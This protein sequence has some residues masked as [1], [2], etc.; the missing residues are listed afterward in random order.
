MV[1][2]DIKEFEFKEFYEKYYLSVYYYVLKKINNSYD[3]EDITCNV[4]TYCYIHFSDYDDSRASIG[5]W[6]YVIVNSRIKNYYRDKKIFLELNQAENDLIN[7]KSL[8]DSVILLEEQ[9]KMLVQA[10]KTLSERQQKI[11]VL[12]Y[13]C[14]KSLSEIA[15]SLEISYGNCRVLLSR[16][17]DKLQKYCQEYMEEGEQ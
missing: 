6:L 15:E 1:S 13:F 5:T 3:A 8:F 4:F 11:V 17:L 12:K 10:I 9:K 7:E 16:A 2:N 14:D